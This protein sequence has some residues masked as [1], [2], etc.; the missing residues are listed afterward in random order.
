MEKTLKQKATTAL[1]W[2]FIDK[3]GQQIKHLPL[4]DIGVGADA[5]G[6]VE[7]EQAVEDRESVEELPLGVAEQ[8]VAPVDHLA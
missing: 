7:G 2:S 8:I 4:V 5:L 6:C 1:A 3:F